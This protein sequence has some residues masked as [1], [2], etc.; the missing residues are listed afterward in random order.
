MNH[1]IPEGSLR[2]ADPLPEAA[3]LAVI[4]GG[5]IGVCTALH[6]ARAGLRVVLCEK[7][8]VAGEQSGRNWG[9][10]RQQGRDDAE[11]P[12]VVEALRLWEGH[13]QS[14]GAAALGFRRTGVAYAARTPADMERFARWLPI[15]AASGVDSRLLSR[16]EL[17]AM[18][19]A[20]AQWQG[21]LWT[22]S[23]AR[24]EPF[25]AVPELARLAQAEG[26]TIREGC[27]VRGLDLS[28]GQ[29]AG[30]ETE[31][32]KV[33]AARVVLAGGAWSRL[34]LARHRVDL[35]QLSVLA[36]VAATGP[37]PA[38]F[39]GALSAGAYAFRRRD[40]GGYTLAPNDTHDFFIGRDAFASLRPFL[41]ILRRDWRSTRLRPAAPSGYPDAWTTPRRWLGESP[42]ERLRVLDPAADRSAIEAARAG[43]RRD[44]PQL[45]EIPIA[46]VW[47]GMIDTMP[48]VVP[49]ID[50]VPD[51][52]GLWV[53][54]GMSG[55]GFGIGPAVG[56]VVADLVQGRPAGHDLTRFRLSRFSD[57]TPID[58]GTAL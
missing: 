51:L 50:A 53:A 22:A 41:K 33:R 39:D 8:R 58:L 5:V 47:A 40:D 20:P 32:G 36:S 37:L 15:A 25:L 48:D 13:A 3:D 17:A 55:H 26:A 54:T 45:G 44:F 46:R 23:D 16:A 49:V 57:G 2:F 35:P 6:A 38:V 12:L 10:I 43:F 24:A 34:F 52:P 42:F 30:V 1:G 9:W 19:P 11:L 29:V 4:G 56:R 7:G 31:A 14:C 21:A 27:A 18:L 28:A